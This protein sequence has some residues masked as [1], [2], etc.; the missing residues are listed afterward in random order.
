MIDFSTHTLANGLTVVLHPDP[1]R[2]VVSVNVLY[3][4]GSRHD[5]P[6]RTGLAHLFE[7]LMFAGS[8]QVPNFDDALQLAGGDNNAVTSSDYTLYYST[9]PANNLETALWLESDRMRQLNFSQ[10]SLDNEKRVVIEEFRETCLEQP[11]GDLYHHLGNLIYRK[12]PY[13]WPVIGQDISHI[14]AVGL[15]DVKH[16]YYRYYRPDNAILCLAGKFDSEMALRSAERWFGDIPPSGTTKIKPAAIL[17][18]EQREFRQLQVSGEVPSPVVYLHCRTVDR[19][20]PDFPATD[21]LSFLL[22]GGRSSLL[23]RRLV[24]DSDLFTEVSTSLNDN[25]EVGGILVDARPSEE[26]DYL[27]AKHALYAAI[28]EMIGRGITERELE[29]VINRLENRNHYKD[30]NVASRASDL[31]FYSLLGKPNWVNTEID[32]YLALTVE[33]INR[34]AKKYL[35]PERRAELEYLSLAAVS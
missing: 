14:Q 30:V 6:H 19:L 18:P 5:P 32:K 33:D 9:L 20:H 4:V 31:V 15:D 26:A 17:E 10:R 27:A 16:F 35:A 28:D 21:V 34:A 7:H 29:K 22:G 11:Y 13:R 1:R 25:L 8:K 24:R 23:Y 3:R 12:H 2:T